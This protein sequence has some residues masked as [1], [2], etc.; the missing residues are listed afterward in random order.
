MDSTTKQNIKYYDAEASA[1]D[2]NRYATPHGRK[3]DALQRHV[4]VDYLTDL[5]P[6]ANILELGCG[7][8]RFL[9]FMS[10]CGYRM[11]GI[12]IS[13][14]MLREARQRLEAEGDD[15][16]QLVTGNA[17]AMNFNDGSFDAVYAILVINLIP[18]YQIPFGEVA[19][20]LKPGGV[21]VLSVPNL[22]SVYFPAGLYVNLRGKTTTSNK[23]GFRYSHWFSRAEII[24]S[25]RQ[26][27]FSVEQI[28]GQ[29]PVLR[30]HGAPK[31]L[32]APLIRWLLAKSVYIK[33]RRN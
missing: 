7:T 33:A 4:L 27:G 24:G 19:R 28:K 29:P 17:C 13:E 26:A 32:S 21:F 30:T 22:S 14:G 18:D 12:D 15:T 11:T 16:S 2:G 25:L 5:A 10:K 3:L 6:K 23:A 8:G 31:P 20:I 9:P 1:Y